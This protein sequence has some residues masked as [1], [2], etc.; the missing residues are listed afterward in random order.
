MFKEEIPMLHD[1]DPNF[2]FETNILQA[3]A[4][5]REPATNPEQLPIHLA[6]AHNVND[7]DDL[8]ARYNESG[9]CYNRYRN[10]NRTALNDLMTYVEGGEASIAFSSGMAAIAASV[11]SNTKAGDHIVSG[12]T[13]YGESIE[14]FKDIL[15][16]YG[17]EASFVDFTDLEAIKAAVKPNTTVFYGE[18]IANPVIAVPDIAAIAEIAHANNAILIID[19]TFMTGALCKPLA[20]GADI[21]V[22]SLKIC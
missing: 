5:F 16:K 6:T 4:Y 13:L 9:F 14:V 22:S 11:I 12:D 17:V 8:Q 18:T 20:L 1:F 15:G 10:P 19:N 3:G 21:V 2:G 7:L